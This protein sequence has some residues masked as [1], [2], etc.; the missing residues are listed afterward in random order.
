LAR[1]VAWTADRGERR[2]LAPGL[3]QETAIRRKTQMT[4]ALAALYHPIHRTIEK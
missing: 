4:P 3:A 2:T 1:E